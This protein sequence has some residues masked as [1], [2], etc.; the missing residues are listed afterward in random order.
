MLSHAFDVCRMKHNIGNEVL[1]T[2]KKRQRCPTCITKVCKLAAFEDHVFPNCSSSAN[3]TDWQVAQVLN[4]LY[5]HIASGPQE[6][7][8]SS[9]SG[10]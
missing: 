1:K 10:E 3:W 2:S 5:D 4:R 6:F 7:S 9:S 8:S